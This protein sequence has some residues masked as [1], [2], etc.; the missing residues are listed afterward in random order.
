MLIK[1]RARE[2]FHNE[3]VRVSQCHFG[4]KNMIAGGIFF[5]VWK[6][7]GGGGERLTSD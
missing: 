6:G 3:T 7:V 5:Q 2:F 4:G 1:L